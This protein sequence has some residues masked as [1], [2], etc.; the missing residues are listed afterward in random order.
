M[1]ESTPPPQVPI[2]YGTTDGKQRTNP[3]AVASLILGI[4][5][6]VPFITGLLAIAIGIIG[7][8]RSRE[9]FMGGKSLSIAGIVLGIIS[10]LAWSSVGGV[11]A[12]GYSESKPAAAVAQSFLKD[13]SAGKIN[14]AMANATGF[15]APQ[16]QAY[17]TQI[18]PFGPLQSVSISSFNFSTVNGRTVMHLGG[19]ATFAKGPRN[20]TFE[21]VKVGATY[22]VTSSWIQ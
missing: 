19:I 15:T 11:L 9:P 12:Y 20:C 5:G 16:L 8:R 21:L 2:T 14:A 6:C 18:I 17:S 1:T 10:V 22:K 3:A 4:L 7:I 13:V